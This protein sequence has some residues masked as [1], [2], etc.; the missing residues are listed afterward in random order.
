MKR[1]VLGRLAWM[2]AILLA[3]SFIAFAMMR[4]LPGDF[5]I[6]AAGSQSVA[7]EVLA[8]IRQDLGLDRSLLAQY[9]AWLGHAILGDLGTSFVTRQPVRPEL[10]DRLAVTFQLTL[11]AAIISMVMGVATGLAAARMRGTVDWIVRLYNGVMLAVPNYVVATLIVLLFGLYFPQVSIFGY[12][13]FLE[14]PLANIGSLLLPAL[15][16]AL[17]VSVTISE[18]TRAAVLEVANQDFVMVAR[19][20]GL[21]PGRILRDYLVRNAMTPVI[22]ATGLKIAALLGG[23]ILVETIFA[24]PGMGQYLFD[25]INSRDYPVIQAIV[26]TASAIVVVVNTMIDIAYA[27]VDARVKL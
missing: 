15:A 3:V 4:A 24:I 13:P 20:K 22:T 10:F 18:N 25:S 23:S 5:A 6:A 1:F 16:L 19:A 11:V 7:P 17:A 27:R 26:L 12:T 8:A 21:P 9:W 2:L 14:D